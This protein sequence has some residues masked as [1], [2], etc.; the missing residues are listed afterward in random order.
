[1]GILEFS[2]LPSGRLPT[3]LMRVNDKE[4]SEFMRMKQARLQV[5]GT[6]S[7]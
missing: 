3:K 4:I 1:M 6:G 5:S 2:E 7:C